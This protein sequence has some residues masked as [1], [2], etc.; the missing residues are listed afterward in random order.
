MNNKSEP[1]YVK[2]VEYERNGLVEQVHFGLVLLMDKKGI[3][4][5]IGD[6]NNYKF[7]HRSCM[8]PLQASVIIDLEIDKKYN[9]TEEEIALCCASHTGDKIHQQY[10][11]SILKKTGF[12][13]NDLL[14]PPHEP[15]SRKELDDIIINR[16]MPQKIHNNCSGKHSAMLAICKE[17]GYSKENYKDLNHPLSEFI[18][19]HVCNLCEVKRTEVTVSKD[20]CGLPVIATTTEQL[21]KGFLNLF[22]NL[23][24]KKIINAFLNNP[25]LIGGEGRLD[26]QIIQNTK[27]VIAKVGACGLCVIVN[28]EKEQAIV[29]KIADSNMEAR[30]ITAFEALKQEKWT[31][32]SSVRINNINRGE[33]RNLDYELVGEI[34]SC[35][36]L[37]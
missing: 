6:D 24:Y 34:K 18:I 1:E 31:D 5:K 33:I 12:S 13:E 35:F 29:I 8:K 23:K 16:L 27:N 25:I 9:L 10:I 28:L 19:Q 7:Y 30:A 2:L 20:G 32:E 14:C 4:K 11:K 17:K 26:T 21:G 3:I 22:T 36:S 37:L 15:L